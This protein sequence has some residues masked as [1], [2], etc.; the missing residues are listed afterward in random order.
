MAEKT[1]KD[2]AG[3]AIELDRPIVFDEGGLDPHTELSITVPAK[4]LGLPGENFYNVPSIYGGV[5]YDP[6]SQFPEI[7]KNV[8]Q[9]VQSGF[10]FPN[11]PSIETAEQAA[12]ARSQYIGQLREEALRQAVERQRQN[13]ILNLMK[14]TR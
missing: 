5:I 1:A 6:Q 10:N 13:L 3:Y 4:E 2:P 7:A 12:Q 11:F 8:Q 9:M 14:T